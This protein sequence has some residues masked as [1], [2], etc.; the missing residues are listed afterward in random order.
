MRSCNFSNGVKITDSRIL[1]WMNWLRT[2]GK[3]NY[4]ASGD[5]F[6]YYQKYNDCELFSICTSDGIIQI[7][8][9]S[10]EKLDFCREDCLK[11]FY[12]DYVSG[13]FTPYQA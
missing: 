11:S 9:K 5:T 7:S 3:S 2:K 4:I 1:E 8:C 6:V 10:F 13:K 12:C